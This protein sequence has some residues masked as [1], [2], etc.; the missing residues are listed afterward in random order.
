MCKKKKEKK[1]FSYKKN[2]KKK[3][4]ANRHLCDM[5][6]VIPDLND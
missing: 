3:T 4:S 6:T 2:S 5:T 1:T